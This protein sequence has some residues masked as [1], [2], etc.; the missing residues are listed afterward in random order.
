M[1]RR[2]AFEIMGNCL[3]TSK[4]SLYELLW[5]LSVLAWLKA[6]REVFD[7]LI[8]SFKTYK[9]ILA[10]IKNEYEMMLAQQRDEINRLLP[11]QV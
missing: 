9:P 1:V 4:F 2:S 3:T 5:P 11:L 8:E 6:Y 10:S 7:Y